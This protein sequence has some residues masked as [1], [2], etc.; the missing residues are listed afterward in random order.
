MSEIHL[1]KCGCGNPTNISP[2]LNTN[3]GYSKGDYF[4][5]LAG[6]YRRTLY[7]PT[8]YKKIGFE[9][10]DRI[11][12][13]QALGRPL[14]S[15]AIVHHLNGT[16]TGPVVICENQGY[17]LLLHVRTRAY[18]ATGNPNKKFC[19]Y[20]KSWDDI[21]NMALH[22]PATY[23]HPLCHTKYNMTKWREKHPNSPRYRIY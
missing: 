13:A 2:T 12:A 7:K 21:K 17:H 5:Y 19:S 4:S 23:R 22:K 14:P 18:L 20:C 16:R 6:H 9:K 11:R 8:Q 1:C 3:L 15:N 10:A